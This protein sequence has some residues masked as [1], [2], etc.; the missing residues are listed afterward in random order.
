MIRI[1]IDARLS[2]KKHAGIGRYVENLLIRLP[3]LKPNVKWVYFFYDKT[4]LAEL[5]QV[6]GQLSEEEQAGVSVAEFLKNVEVRYAPIKH[7]SLKEQKEMPKVFRGASL[8]LLHVPHF[9]IPLFYRGKIVITIHDL[10]WHE[11]KGLEATTLKPWM[12]WLK[13]AFYRL[14]TGTAIRRAK[15]IFVPAETTARHI[16][17]FYPKVAEK[18]V[19][20]KEGFYRPVGRSV[21]RTSKK[22]GDLKDYLLYV[23]SLYPHKNVEVILEA[24][25]GEL[26]E[27]ELVVVGARNV[28]L[29]TIKKK[30]KELDLERRVHF[31]GFVDDDELAVIYRKAKVLIQPSFWEG[32]GL[33]GLEAIAFG[34]SI[35]VSDIEI[36]HEVYGQA[37]WFFNP[38][39]AIELA[40][41]IKSLTGKQREVLQSLGRRQLLKYDWQKMSLVTVENYE[42]VLG[43]CEV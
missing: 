3:L 17:S 32:F 40:E 35:L 14:I 5:M 42:K 2:G 1:G 27:Q 9:N 23:G 18:I 12:Y 37:A 22:L 15:K 33:T 8:D 29:E 21:E 13:Y 25:A 24:M 38:N 11:K 41:K 43:D 6:F 36:F 20:T 31:L 26:A 39:S 7:Y 16:L 28:F 19:I 4:Q 10:L 30:V 34:T